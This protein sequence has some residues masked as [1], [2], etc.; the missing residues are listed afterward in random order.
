MPVL[1][2]NNATSTL[3]AGIAA[4]ATSLTVSAGQGLRF[5][6][7]TGGDYFY[8]TL[9][10]NAGAIEIIK[11]TA[12]TTDTLT[13]TRA[14]DGTTAL[15]WNAGDR[16][17]V[18]ITKAMLDDLKADARAGS[19]TSNLAFSGTG[20]RITGDFSNATL[21]NRVAFQ[22]S[23]T[24]GNSTVTVLPNGTATISQFAAYSASSPDNTA[25]LAFQS[26]GV[27]NQ[28]L[29]NKTGSGTTLPLLFMMDGAEAARFAT[30]RNLLVGGT[31]DNATDKLQVT[32]SMSLSSA[33]RVGASPS[34]GTAGQVLTSA[35]AGAAP[36]WATATASNLQ[37]FTSSGTWT[38][39]SGAQFVM[40][41]VWGAGGGGGSGSRAATSSG[42]G[43]GGGGGGFRRVVFKASS[44]GATET[45]TIGLGGSGG[46]SLAADNAT[47]NA[48]GAGGS[49]SFGAW[50]SA[51]GGAGGSGGNSSGIPGGAG[52]GSLASSG[53]TVGFGGAAA[54]T[55]AAGSPSGWGGGSGGGGGLFGGLAGGGSTL[56][57]GG[58]GSGASL[59][60]G[61]YY[62]AGGRGGSNAGAT[63]GG[64]LAGYALTTGGAGGELQ[65][66]GGGGAAGLSQASFYRAAYG[67]STFA[68]LGDKSIATSSNAT[69]WTHKPSPIAASNNYGS[70]FYDGAKWVIFGFY[71]GTY[72]IFTTTDFVTYTAKTTPPQSVRTLRYLNGNYVGVGAAGGI[73]TSTD[74]T[75]WTQRTSGV[76]QNL[77]DVCWTGTNY[78]ACGNTGTVIYSSNLSTWTAVTGLPTAHIMC[79]A[80]GA[81][82]RVVYANSGGSQRYS[83]D[84]GVTFTLATTG[85]SPATQVGP[86]NLEYLN[87]IFV[88]AADN[89]IWSSSDGNT[90][91]SQSAGAMIGGLGYGGGMY[92]FANSS[93]SYQVA[94]GSALTSLTSYT[95]TGSSGPGNAGGAGGAAGGGGGG[96][97][98]ASGV[99]SGAGG[100]GGNGLVRV[101][102]W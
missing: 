15:A 91:A 93:T 98:S 3:S 94:S 50:A 79:I 58:G 64:G 81:S 23:T 85:A 31:T 89:A 41:D 67:N 54:T 62:P 45:V 25:F 75:T 51:Y 30:S 69:S 33:L 34:A 84:H 4:G 36:T 14:Q 76:S 86:T 43:G 53:E 83:T 17:E 10:N 32:G 57:G 102:T 47:G 35:G 7:P 21:S 44:L 1:Y 60:N 11:V 39:P 61:F 48:G 2:T 65:G 90:W 19:Y 99:A 77:W 63:G 12:R 42:G 37:E 6:S 38:K 100:A 40:V 16:I 24:N 80:A 74:L 27:T 66:G 82:G 8:A 5:P 59:N 49:S 101:Y 71:G 78:V 73:W 46:A 22:S 87:G 20:L 96:S 18:R 52:G 13:V 88:L 72:E 29:S 95:P 70:I 28:I 9:T 92:F 56:G 55:S 97:A 26:N 68:I